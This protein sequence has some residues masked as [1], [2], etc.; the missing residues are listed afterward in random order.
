MSSTS[1]QTLSLTSPMMFITVDSFGRGRRLSMIARSA[2][3]SRFAIA[4]ARTTPPTSGDT[5]I[6]LSFALM[7]PDV[8][9]QHRRGVHVVERDVEETLDLVRMQVDGQHAVGT[10]HA[11]HLR[12]DL[13]GDRHAR[14]ARPPVLARVAEIRHHRGHAC[15]RSA[16][17]RIDERQQLHEIVGS[18][19]AGRL[20]HEHFLAAHVFLDLDLHLAVG[21][22]ADQRLAER[23]VEFPADRRAPDRDWRCR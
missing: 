4:R 10:D 23:H 7:A 17:E 18:R 14:R 13:G 6:R 3:S 20:D 21:E 5:T 22:A 8:G 1:T 11:D 15:R 2:S 9:Q 19:R 12:R 16:L